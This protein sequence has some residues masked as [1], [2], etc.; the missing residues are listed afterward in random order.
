L[1]DCIAGLSRGL[2]TPVGS[3][4]QMLSSGQAQRVAIARAL[5][6]DAHLLVLD[7]PTSNLDQASIAVL[8]ETLRI[9]AQ[10]RIVVV[11]SHDETLQAV[12]DRVFRLEDGQLHLQK[13]TA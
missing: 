10:D 7:E 8:K 11:V 9:V 6:R 4:G 5:Y 1:Q 2:D 3:G 13:G 12:C